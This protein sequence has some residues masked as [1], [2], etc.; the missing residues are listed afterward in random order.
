MHQDSR[1]KDAQNR[2]VEEVKDITENYQFSGRRGE[3]DYGR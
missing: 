3:H 1:T 2:D